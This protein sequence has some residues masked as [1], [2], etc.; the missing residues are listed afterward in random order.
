MYAL[1]KFQ[2][3]IPR[4]SGVMA[5]QSGNSK[6]DQFLQQELGKQITSVS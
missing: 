6:K 3:D 5:L 2:T 1:A 4:T